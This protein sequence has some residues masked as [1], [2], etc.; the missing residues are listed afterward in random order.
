M[1]DPTVAVIGPGAIGLVAVGALIDAGHRPIVAARTPFERLVVRRPGGEELNH[2]LDVV[3]DPEEVAGPVDLVF[4]ATKAHQS[5][6]VAPWFARLCGP[7]TILAALQNG[8]DH[9]DRLAPYVDRARVV[10]VV[11]NLP[12][13]REAPGVVAIGGRSFNLVVPADGP[14]GRVAAALDGSFLPVRQADDFVTP[15]WTKLLIN[16]ATGIL[17]V[18]TGTPNG[19]IADADAGALFRALVNEA[20]VVARAEGASIPDDIADRAMARILEGD[21]DH[22]SSITADRL[23]GS[24]TEWR[25][26]NQI[27]VD[28]ADRHGIDVPLNR[29]GTTLIRLGEPADT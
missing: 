5:D 15:A 25:I 8:I 23:A 27:V 29:A 2:P 16:S 14:G 6:A 11:V 22:V 7:E 10:P 20:A 13:L 4:L 19:V 28:L 12:A 21:P 9:R 18:L 17:G 3:T 26:R 1:S 24:P